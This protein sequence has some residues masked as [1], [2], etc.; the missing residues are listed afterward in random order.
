MRNGPRLEA[1]ILREQ[2]KTLKGGSVEHYYIVN[3]NLDAAVKAA[4]AAY[5]QTHIDQM[6]HRHAFGVSCDDSCRSIK[7]YA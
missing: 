1:N 3:N 7:E 2:T 5:A 6:I 4:K